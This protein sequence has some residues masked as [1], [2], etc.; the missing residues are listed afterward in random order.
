MFTDLSPRSLAERLDAMGTPVGR[1]A[2]STW[3]DEAGIRRRKIRKDIPGGKHPDRNAQ[4]ERIAA[5]I[6]QYE[7]AG[8]PWFSV[9]TKAKEHLGKL[10][11]KGQ[12]QR[13]LWVN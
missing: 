3:L 2:I 8:N 12:G 9:D 5:L 7:S 11:R 13:A 4:F 1:D 6:E 10:Y